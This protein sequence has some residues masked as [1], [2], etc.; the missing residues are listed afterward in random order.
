VNQFIFREYDIRGVAGVDLTPEVDN[1]VGKGVG[2]YM[3]NHG[4]S[5]VSVGRDGRWSSPE[6]F[7]AMVKGLRSVGVTVVDLGIIPTPLSYYSAYKLDVGGTIMITGS[8]NPPDHN[9]FKITMRTGGIFGEEI[10]VIKR[11]ILENAYTSGKGGLESYNI[12][13]E[14]LDDMAGRLSLV[15]PVSIGVDCGNGVGGLTAGPLLER[16]GC[17][18]TMLYDKIDGT[19]PNHHPDPTLPETMVDLA[20]TVVDNKLECGFAYDG[21]ADRIGMVDEKGKILWGDQILAIIARSILKERP[22]AIVIG[23]VKCSE[24]LYEDIRK[25]GGQPLMY[26]VGHSLAKQKMLEV[27]AELGGEVSGHIYIKHRFYGFD[28]AIY[29]TGRMLEIIA[30]SD[31]PVSRFL[32]DWPPMFNTPELKI[33]CGDDV[34]FEVVEKVKQYFAPRYTINDIDGMRVSMPGGWGLVRASNTTPVLTLRFEANSEN[35][36][37][38]IQDE[39]ESAVTNILKQYR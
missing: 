1:L 31:I 10:Q 27:G 36:L 34:K 28:D 12:I 30:K 13:P 32:E 24:L 16:L 33:D 4:V 38:E 3:M 18:V 11:I 29:N 20:K 9:G 7:E 25:H 22:G 15:R 8:H 6:I 37:K 21:D 5:R 19:F 14:Y 2:T 23:E 39:V 35:R 26:K 17:K